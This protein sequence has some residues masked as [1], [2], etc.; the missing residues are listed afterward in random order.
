[1]CFWWVAINISS[2]LDSAV[3][4]MQKIHA[5]LWKSNKVLGFVWVFL[6][7][8]K[9][10]DSVCCGSSDYKQALLY[11]SQRLMTNLQA[12]YQFA[13]YTYLSLLESGD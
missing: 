7:Q 8:W 12:E 11:K 13:F 3:N 1:M 10:Y 2:E 5:G 9:E 6:I 4:R